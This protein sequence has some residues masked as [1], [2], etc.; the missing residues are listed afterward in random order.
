M[1]VTAFEQRYVKLEVRPLGTGTYGEVFKVNDTQTNTVMAMKRMKLEHEE[2]GIPSTAIREIAVLKELHH[3][4][5]VRLYDVHCSQKKLL[6]VFEY[7]ANDLKRF[8]RANKPLSAATI[9][10]LFKQLL[11]GLEFCHARRVIHRDL[12]PANLLIDE[13]N[14][15]KI[16]DFGL[17]R[18]FALP[19]PVLTHEVVTVWYRPPEILL[20]KKEY[21]LGCDVWSMGAILA[22]MARGSPLFAGDSEID[23][24]FKIFRQ[25]GTPHQQVWPGVEELKEYSASFPKW[26]R[27]P[28]ELQPALGSVLGPPGV[29]LLDQCLVY[30]PPKRI[31]ARRALLSRYFDDAQG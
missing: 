7:V 19:I 18:A 22:E 12:K 24:L 31:S 28:W 3:V 4:N 17:A 13:R 20:N 2:E 21:G 11:V 8:L 29:E 14:Q 10:T 1:A 5:V 30:N 16:A 27:Q 23:T 15:L 25:L 26:R 6:L 9:C